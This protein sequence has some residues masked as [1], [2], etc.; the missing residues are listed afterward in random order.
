MKA[1][2]FG[3]TGKIGNDLLEFLEKDRRFHEIILVQRTSREL[4][5]RVTQVI[6]DFVD[7][8]AI[9]HLFTDD[10]SVFCAIGT[11]RKKTPD[12]DKYRSIDVGIPVK[13]AEMAMKGGCPSLHVVSSVGANANDKSFY[14]RTK[15]EME[16]EVR[17]VFTQG[18][19]HFYRPSLL[20]GQRKESRF[21]ERM[22]ITMY[23][24]FDSLLRGKYNKYRGIDSK[25]VARAMIFAAT[26][27]V[28]SSIVEFDQIK[29]WSKAY[30][31]G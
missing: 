23:P 29:S 22:F 26:E 28:P 9:E 15:G 6:F 19:L 13:V 14:L 31:P 18:Q 12:I 25:E 10:I 17:R 27:N 3:S 4:S 2:V 20:L 8:K 16:D 5:Q 7:W 30:K 11:T 21:F 24:V 1:L